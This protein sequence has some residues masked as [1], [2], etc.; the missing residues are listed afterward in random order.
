[1]SKVC[2]F[3]IVQYVDGQQIDQLLMVLSSYTLHH[4]SS[5]AKNEVK[6]GEDITPLG[7]FKGS[8]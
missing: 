4:E 2:G 5:F 6:I 8:V 1:M 3:Q 7:F